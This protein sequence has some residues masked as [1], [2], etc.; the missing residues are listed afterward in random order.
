MSLRVAGRYPQSA[1]FPPDDWGETPKRFWS[2]KPD[3]SRDHGDLLVVI[4]IGFPFGKFLD[5]KR[6]TSAR[7]RKS[8]AP[9][10][11]VRR[12]NDSLHPSPL[13]AQRL[14]ERLFAEILGPLCVVLIRSDARN[15]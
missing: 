11:A 4:P 3:R 8:L 1:R 10:N 7:S 2:E 6:L 9:Q 14:D 12:M 5:Q 15:Q 13:A